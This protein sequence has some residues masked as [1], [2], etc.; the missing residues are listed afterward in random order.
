MKL[1]YFFTLIIVLMCG[2]ESAFAQTL[3]RTRTGNWV[4]SETNSPVDYTP[5]VVAVARSLAKDELSALELSISCRNG[6]ANLILTGAAKRTKSPAW[7]C[8]RDPKHGG[9]IS[10]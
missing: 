6:R 8:T 4:I 7:R 2:K 1:A 10:V 9:K 5:V 3:P